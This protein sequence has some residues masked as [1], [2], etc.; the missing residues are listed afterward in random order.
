MTCSAPLK[1]IENIPDV[2]LSLP[3]I[4]SAKG[5][6]KTI[7]PIMDDAEHA[8]LKTSA[9]ILKNALHSIGF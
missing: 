5:I 9:E 4:V 1:A 3:H 7:W 2:T 6:V 8:A